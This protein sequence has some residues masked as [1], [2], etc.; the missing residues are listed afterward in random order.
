MPAPPFAAEAHMTY[1]KLE[2]LFGA[3]LLLSGMGLLYH[4]FSPRY[5]DMA[6]DISVGPMF[7]PR[8]VLTLWLLCSAGIIIQALH[9]RKETQEFLWKRV[10]IVFLLMALF[11]ALFMY[12][13]FI[14]TGSLF[15]IAMSAFLG[16]RRPLVL[17]PFAVIY[18]VFVDYL[19]RELLLFYLPQFSFAF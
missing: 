17:I 10:C 4:T 5:E 9:S 11:V 19:F 3:L 7:F 16:Y 6:Q 13:G 8:I 14:L 2:C 1:K 18:I 15:F 12:G